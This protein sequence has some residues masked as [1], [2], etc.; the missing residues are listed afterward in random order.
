M[1]EA[2][3][4]YFVHRFDP[5]IAVAFGA[6][7]LAIALGL[8]LFVDHYIAP[9]Y[10][11]AVIMVAVFG[12]MA[13]DVLHVRFGI[14]YY[15]TSVGFAIILAS[16]FVL[17]YRTEQ[18]LSIHSIYTGRRELFYWATVM[19]TFALG[20]AVGDMTAMTFH[21]GYF[22]SGILFAVVIAVPTLA[23]RFAGMNAIFAFWFAYIVTRPLG[24]SFA[25]WMGVPHRLGGLNWGRGNV[26]LALTAVIVV[27]VAY[28]TVSRI[29][30]PDEHNP[31]SAGVVDPEAER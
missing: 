14:P 18:T 13:A 10:W 21:L 26:S 23:Y 22:S 25:D 30:V 31:N 24:A 8:Q 20:T 2:T 29:D 11:L 27:F 16:V 1:G 3:S 28:L 5:V 17:W 12:T 4:D 19:A 15:V 9:V 7:A 6:I